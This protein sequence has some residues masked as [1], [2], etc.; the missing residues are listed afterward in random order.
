M[1]IVNSEEGKGGEKVC[2][3]HKC[4]K[5]KKR[6]ERKQGHVSMF[7]SSKLQNWLKRAAY[8]ILNLSVIN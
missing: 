2:R 6:R 7:F 1:G 5:E 3:G 8:I 4:G